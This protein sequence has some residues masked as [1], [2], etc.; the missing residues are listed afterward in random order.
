M[1]EVKKGDTIKVHYHGTL[2]DGTIFDSS[3]G[4]EP[5]EFEVGAGMMIEG[6]DQGVLGMVLGVKKQVSIPAEQAYGDK[7]E[8][9]I[10][11]FPIDRFPADMVPE[12]GMQL[13]MSN[14]EGDSFPVQIIE[15]ADEYVLLDGN[16]PL[17]GKDLI[18][19]IE[20]VDIQAKSMIIMP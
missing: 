20:V 18:F 16:H 12:V 8:D 2:T 13:N 19:D 9:M 3:N 7:R 10:M 15:V 5:L 11:E 4:R 6:F 1:Q 17:A 14:N